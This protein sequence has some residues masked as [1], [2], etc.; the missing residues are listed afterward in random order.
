MIALICSFWCFGTFAASLRQSDSIEGH[1]VLC[2]RPLARIMHSILDTG[3]INLV[4]GAWILISPATIIIPASAITL[5][6]IAYLVGSVAR[7]TYSSLKKQPKRAS[8][9]P[10]SRDASDQI[11][12]G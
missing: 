7:E 1:S 10:V 9:S 3:L 8:L 4:L 11:S 12:I 5:L 6:N 2:G